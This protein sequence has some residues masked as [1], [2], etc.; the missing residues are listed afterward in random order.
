MLNKIRSMK[1]QSFYSGGLRFS[2]TRCSSC[3][4]HESGFV[5]LSGKDTGLLA[6]E[7]QMGYNDF[8]NTYCR[9]TPGFWSAGQG[10]G[11]PE[12][13]SLREKPNFDCI[14][15]N[16]ACT[17]YRAR[18]LQCRV[19]PFWQSIL[20]SEDAWNAAA[21]ECP[22]MNRGTLHG[23]DEIEDCLAARAAEPIITRAVVLENI[24]FFE[25]S[26]PKPGS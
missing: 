2:C 15:W 14:F 13:L 7:C 22:G 25:P 17:V 9:W 16:G 26:T 8:V 1:K 6:D 4:R 19:F 20:R 12:R 3:C 5:F 24:R 11:E 23:R 18:P 10:D 21:A